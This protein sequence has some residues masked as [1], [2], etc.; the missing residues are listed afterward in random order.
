[1][2]TPF[3]GHALEYFMHIYKYALLDEENFYYFIFSH[4]F[5]RYIDNE[6]LVSKNNIII[7]YLSNREYETL[8]YSNVFVNSYL[9]NKL[10]NE[11]IRNNNITDVI[12]CSYDRWDPL[13][14]FM[15]VK[16]VSYIGI[17]YYIYLY[18]W[19]K[20]SIKRRLLKSLIF[21]RMAHNKVIKKICIC[22]DSSSAMFFNRKYSTNK[23][24]AISDP[25]VPI[26]NTLSDF[27]KSNNIELDAV[28]FSHIG[29]LSERKGTLNILE[30]ILKLHIVDENKY[31]FVFAG[32][33]ESN[34][35]EEF[36]R[37]A[38]LCSK[39]FRIIIRDCFCSYEE[40]AAICKSSN[41]LLIPYLNTSQSSGILG[42]AAQ[43]NVP[44]FSPNS[45]MLGKII[46][47]FG[48][49]YLKDDVTTSGIL[50]F[51]ESY[52]LNNPMMID[53]EKYLRKN[54]VDSFLRTLMK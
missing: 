9:L 54:N 47:R 34:I 16:G 13:F 36:Y 32:K 29:V 31:V 6:C 53:G 30:A 15:T 22:N 41:V 1:M 21:W 39:K 33:I 37:L 25:Y 52:C 14:A 11:K 42:Y 12:M 10:L 40:I 51:L 45:K 44:V 24:V 26:T 7:Q 3:G 35:K 49:G 8:K 4:D 46:R 20:M 48:L 38:S 2:Y 50:D 5:K 23:F 18:E 19:K 17:Y 43:F 28:V 27:R